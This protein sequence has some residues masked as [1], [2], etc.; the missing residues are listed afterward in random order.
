ML[1]LTSQAQTARLWGWDVA[2]LAESLSSTHKA[3]G[4]TSVSHKPD[5]VDTPVTLALRQWVQKDPNFKLPIPYPKRGKK[6]NHGA[7]DAAEW[8]STFLA[9][10]RSCL[11]PPVLTKKKQGLGLERQFSG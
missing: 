10:I 5:V 4:L 9:C 6:K 8:S 1:S 11:Q 2:Q 3:L 7:G